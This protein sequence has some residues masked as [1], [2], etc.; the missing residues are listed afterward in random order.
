[1]VLTLAV[2]F[3]RHTRARPRPTSD[4]ELEKTV[5]DVEN[6]FADAPEHS[7]IGPGIA[8]VPQHRAQR[9]LH[10][11]CGFDNQAERRAIAAEL[12]VEAAMMEIVKLRSELAAARAAKGEADRALVVL[13]LASAEA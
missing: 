8:E 11:E 5:R 3:A 9:Q 2:L 13:Q 6:L 10:M 1:M 4:V 12:E 7:A